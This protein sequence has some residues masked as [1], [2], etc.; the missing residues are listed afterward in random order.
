MIMEEKTELKIPGFELYTI[1][2]TANG[3]VEVISKRYKRP[4]R[5][6]NNGNR[7]TLR[8]MSGDR[9]IRKHVSPGVLIYL[10]R[11]PEVSQAWWNHVQTNE[12]KKGNYPFINDN[13]EVLLRK[14]YLD[15]VG[16]NRI[17]K[18]LE[19]A[20]QTVWILRCVAKTKKTY[21]LTEWAE[22]HYRAV[23]WSCR[24]YISMKRSELYKGEAIET[25]EKI[26]GE[27]S[28]MHIRPLFYLLREAIR[29][30]VEKRK[31]EKA[32][33]DPNRDINQ[34]QEI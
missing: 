24:Q 3:E 8:N 22:E 29:R 21:L 16:A 32:K 9:T 30:T 1:Y 34:N 17:F 10:S 27:I 14:E 25:F 11:N 19:E 2:R 15:K 33:Y 13:G 4:C 12:E 31:K 28:V 7:W 23:A 20:Y 5:K 26:C 18:S 6:D